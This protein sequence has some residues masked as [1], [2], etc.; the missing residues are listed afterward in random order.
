MLLVQS[1]ART[2]SY[3]HRRFDVTRATLWNSLL[4][5]IR[6]KKNFIRFKDILMAS[7]F[8]IAYPEYSYLHILMVVHMSVLNPISIR[9]HSS[10]TFRHC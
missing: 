9:E 1:R 7:I 4:E 2:K 8:S 10:F 5:N 3:G 6:S